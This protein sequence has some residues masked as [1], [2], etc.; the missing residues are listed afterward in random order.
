[1]NTNTNRSR[2]MK[3]VIAIGLIG[4]LAACGE[5]APSLPEAKALSPD[6]V[7][8]YGVSWSP[9]G[10]RIAYWTPAEDSVL[11]AQLWVANADFSSPIKLPVIG[12]A[13][14]GNAIPATWS[15]DGSKLAASSSQFG[16]GDV[17]V[18]PS[19][20]GPARRVTVGPG[21]S[22]NGFWNRD[23]DRI[24]IVQTAEG[25]TIRTASFSLASGKTVPLVAH[26]THPHVAHW[27][28]DGS[29]V[30]YEQFDG[31]KSTI[32]V[33]DSAGE[34]AR[35]LTSEGFES[36]PAF[37]GTQPWSPDGKEVLYES[38]RTGTSDLWIVP[39]DGGK[40]RQLTRDIRNDYFETWSGDGKSVA[41]LSDRGRKID[42]WAVPAAGGTEARVTDTPAEELEPP[43]FRPGT[44]E[45]AFVGSTSLSGVWSAD[46]A[47][48]KEARLTPDSLRTS[49][50]NVAPDGKQFDFVIERGGGIQD[51]AVE[52]IDGGAYRTLTSGGGTVQNPLWSPSGS[53]IAFASD[54][55]GLGDI[56][57]IDAT[58]GAPKQLE[59]WPGF[60]QQP[61]WALNDSWIYFVSDR[62]TKLGDVWKVAPTGGEPAR[63]THDGVI[64]NLNGRRG[65][66]ALFVNTIGQR[67]GVFPTSRIGADGKLHVIWDKS[68]SFTAAISPRGD[69]LISV[70]DQPSGMTQAMIFPANGGQ[71]RIVLPPSEAPGDWSPDGK[72]ICYYF[73]AGGT[74]H[75]GILTL[76]GGAKRPLTHSPDTDAGV[77]WTPDGKKVLFVRYHNV[78]RIFTADLSKLLAAPK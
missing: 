20:G 14:A 45:V 3:G 5:R 72:L 18:V 12:L 48:G 44:S 21:I 9:D 50:F 1:M 70:V 4:I 37:I 27:S 41:F 78:S 36:Y 65:V 68:N 43:R 47:D 26:E 54:R 31:P 42:V 69:S 2:M 35:Q 6:A 56:F 11:G 66:D 7:R 8:Q 32:W 19:T 38:R 74:N 49:F 76:A 25:G 17:V 22:F 10:K 34:H 15:P 33:A 46:V 58:G 30:V 51:I 62:D 39:I 59:N 61:T 16:E 67:G 40:A 71:G 55:A 28:P 57:V 73:R 60:E 64:N 53:K 52:S 23:G 63:V 24:E 77:E 29:H 75:I 13:T